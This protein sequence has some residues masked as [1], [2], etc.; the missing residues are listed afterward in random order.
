M[1][2]NDA[3]VN[4]NLQ[5]GDALEIEWVDARYL[6]GWHDRQE[7][8]SWERDFNK[9]HSTGFFVF[10][11]D[12]NLLFAETWS[13]PGWEHK[14][15]GG[16]NS[17]T[18]AQILGIWRLERLE[19]LERTSEPAY[20]ME[21]TAAPEPIVENRPDSKQIMLSS[22]LLSA[23][24]DVGILPGDVFTSKGSV[25]LA[26]DG[27]AVAIDA[28]L[29]LP[30]DKLRQA[31]D[32]VD[33]KEKRIGHSP[34]DAQPPLERSSN[35]DIARAAL[36]WRVAERSY[37]EG[38]RGDISRGADIELAKR[39]GDANQALRLALDERIAADARKRERGE[40]TDTAL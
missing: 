33:R 8:L 24:T 39:A 15:C 28:S 22:N 14:A 2:T 3:V 10:A 4:L 21:M 34:T 31:L 9:H 40:S 35:D 29:L 12:D 20:A 5:P 6:S 26:L 13:P 17:I 30:A 32:I 36:L 16:V 1:I 38:I 25:R 19:V 27:P 37:Q 18:L 23:L 7:I 11:N